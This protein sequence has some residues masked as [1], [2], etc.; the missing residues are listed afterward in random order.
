M[1][2]EQYVCIAKVIGYTNLIIQ[3]RNINGMAKRNI[4]EV[5]ASTMG[6]ITAMNPEQLK[7]VESKYAIMTQKILGMD[8]LDATEV[9]QLQ[10]VADLI[11][12]AGDNVGE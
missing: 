7:L 2:N 6:T 12:L 3:S 9:Q 10:A 5:V 1:T 11:E 4:I 8:G